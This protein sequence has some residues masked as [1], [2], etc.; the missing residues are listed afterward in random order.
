MKTT[1][2]PLAIKIISILMFVLLTVSIAMLSPKSGIQ[3]VF[4]KGVVNTNPDTTT[5]DNDDEEKKKEEQR[6]EEAKKR[7][8][9]DREE[10]RRKEQQTRDDQQ[11]R[12]QQAREDKARE[13]QIKR[14]QQEREE[15]RKRDEEAREVQRKQE[16][17]RQEQIRRDQQTREDQKRREQQDIEDQEKREKSAREER[18]RQQAEQ[19]RIDREN[20]ERQNRT[21]QDNTGSAQPGTSGGKQ[22]TTNQND[23]DRQDRDRRTEPD[24]ERRPGTDRDT[25]QRKPGTPDVRGQIQKRGEKRDPDYEYRRHYYDPFY[26][27][28]DPYFYNSY[29]YDYRDEIVVVK[30]KTYKKHTP[31]HGYT[32]IEPGSLDEILDD[33]GL[34]W[35]EYDPNLLMKHVASNAKIDV[36]YN[37]KSSHSITYR[38]LYKLTAE[39]LNRIETTDFRFTSIKKTKT[40]ARAK[41][42][43]EFY[44]PSKD[45]RIAYLTYYLN[46]TGSRW[47]ITRID[48]RENDY[49]SPSCF[50]A[51]AAY[52]TPMEDDVLTLRQF[53]DKYLLTNPAGRIFVDIYYTISPPIADQIRENDTSRSIVRALLKPIVQLCRLAVP[54]NGN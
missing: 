33:I 37:N 17:D 43:H 39:S 29:P 31:S 24:S 2:N 22:N 42:R 53:R 50:I 20:Q 26:Y 38:Q 41:A 12:E 34:T 40:T 8:E 52:G 49:G 23:R 16:Q 3:P 4:A 7:E 45:A 54:K 44:G 6:K 32:K 19:D 27:P 30:P 36:Y 18:E 1:Q 28:Y 14:E 51:T 11:R 35:T 10:Q 21:K 25:V 13:E 48:I 47:L 15:Q 5:P 9:Q 46:R